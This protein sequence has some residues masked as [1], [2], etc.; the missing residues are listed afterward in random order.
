M[1]REGTLNPWE[2]Q[3]G[4]RERRM[5]SRGYIIR[6]ALKW[7]ILIGSLAAALFLAAGTTRIPTLR[8]YIAAFSLLLLVTM[9]AVDPGLAHE[10]A[11][12]GAG[13]KDTRARFGAGFLF[14]VT[15]GFAAMDVGRLHESDRVPAAVSVIALV[16]FAA[17]L[18][19]QVWAMIVNPF[20]SPV[21]RIQEERSHHVIACG[22][23]RW[24]RHPGYLAMLI[25]IPA[26][27]LAI[28]SWLALIPAAGFCAVIVRRARLEDRFLRGNLAGYI[29]YMARVP[30]GLFCTRRH[31]IHQ[32]VAR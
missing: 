9:L 13:A 25:A 29:D 17:V 15:V 22:P 16:V 18:G 30:G 24:L 8:A 20:F 5:R 14:L 31:R 7:V 3:Q 32:E 10:R 1:R 12:P 2:S 27:A 6:A 21:I 26:S 19:F 28:G 4:M 11:H 23:Y